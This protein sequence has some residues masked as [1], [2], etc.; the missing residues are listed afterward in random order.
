MVTLHEDVAMRTVLMAVGV[1]VMCL[2]LCFSCGVG[3]AQGEGGSVDQPIR[4]LWKPGFIFKTVKIGE[5]KMDYVV[6]VPRAYALEKEW[7]AIVFLHGSGESGTDGQKQIAQG[8]GTNILWNA[9]RWPC[10]VMMPQKPSEKLQWEDEDDLVMKMLEETKKEYR[11]D[12]ERIA[13][14]G[15]SQG[16]HGTWSIGAAHP[17][18]W[19]ALAPICGYA[20]REGVGM[21][22][23][24][25]AAKLK[26][27]P[28][29]VFHGE[30]DN[31]VLPE[32]S[33]NV[34]E[35]MRAAGA[36]DVRLTLYPKTNHGSWDK[37]YGEKDLPGFLMKSK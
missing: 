8:I 30:E 32:Q 36:P 27:V 33:K 35:A 31:V 6:Y 11:I 23:E 10:I 26:G 24:E 37:A 17:G 29:W 22:A 2:M 25:I 4:T 19:C 5:R 13:L 21:R 20:D 3:G 16:G 9:D 12:D 18:V 15:L 34:V 28:M 14:T 7:P 1:V